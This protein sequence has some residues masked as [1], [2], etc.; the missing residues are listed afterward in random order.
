VRACLV[1][2]VLLTARLPA[3]AQSCLSASD[4]EAATRASLESTA[5]RYFEFA[6]KGDVFSLKQNS[7]P[8]VAANFSGIE[9]AVVDNKPS[10]AEA[11]P[12]PRPPFRLQVSGDAPVAHAEF[13]CGVFGPNGQT[14]D[15]A[16]FA[17]SNLPPGNY[18][19]VIMDVSGSKGPYTFSLVLQQMGSDWK[20]G[21][22]Y[23]KPAQAAGHDAQWFSER[24]REFKAKG[25]SRNAWFYYQQAR[26]LLAPVPFMST[27]QTDKL[28]DE[29]HGLEPGDLPAGGNTID[30]A[31]GSKTF[32]V[33]SI[34]P[35]A[36]GNDL[37]LVVKYQSADVTDTTH[38]FQDNM[39]VIKALV[40][41]YPEY[42]EAF[43]AVVARA[44][45]PSG[46]DY[47]SLLA[48]KDIK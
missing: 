3:G 28:Y 14:R 32:K 6:A 2:F 48:M 13:L 17:L 34:F 15:S 24:A 43:A 18:A 7:I 11:H 26:D 35:L 23:A 29:S 10:F 5:K 30:L 1:G 37:D 25:Q 38:T 12:A 42:R 41:K 21:G 33:T 8:S 22:F 31:A 46:R 45:E 40:A 36:V 19:I 39:A 27:L 44:V 9:A 47:G 16:V 4:M 20:M